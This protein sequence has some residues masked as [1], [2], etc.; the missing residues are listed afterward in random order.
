MESE[1]LNEISKKYIEI[2]CKLLDNDKYSNNK[3]SFYYFL[4]NDI[5]PFSKDLDISN[6]NINNEINNS[7]NTI[8]EYLENIYFSENIDENIINK[9]LKNIISNKKKEI[10]KKI[11]EC[12]K[13]IKNLQKFYI[14]LTLEKY[15]PSNIKD[16]LS[17]KDRN[18]F[19]LKN[20]KYK[21]SLGE[22]FIRFIF[23]LSSLKKSNILNE[24]N[25]NLIKD[26][27]TTNNFYNFNT[28]NNYI[29]LPSYINNYE[30]IFKN[31]QMCLKKEDI[32][33]NFIPNKFT[34]ISNQ[35]KYWILFSFVNDFFNN[36]VDF[37]TILNYYEFKKT[38]NKYFLKKPEL[39]K[40]NKKSKKGGFKNNIK[41]KPI[42]SK[43]NNI[44]SLSKIINSTN[45]KSKIKLI[46]KKNYKNLKK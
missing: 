18:V 28:I 40:K 41:R 2:F 38:I 8:S 20:D 11:N 27:F 43:K 42:F 21:Y 22:F 32:K 6:K 16:K 35:F 46:I 31:K 39:K 7:Y 45:K 15:F 37:D 23:T 13:E 14:N 29:L 5:I 3:E 10:I 24:D 34:D 9:H 19:Y 4:Y 17:F 26:N 33:N 30:Y 36:N 1:K 44:L 25:I 12:N